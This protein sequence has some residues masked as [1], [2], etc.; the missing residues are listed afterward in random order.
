MTINGIS[1]SQS[2][3]YVLSNVEEYKTVIIP[4][5]IRELAVASFDEES[6]FFTF[7]NT[8][9]S[10]VPTIVEGSMQDGVKYVIKYQGRRFDGVDYIE[11][12]SAPTRAGT[13]T[14]NCYFFH[15]SDEAN[16]SKYRLLA[17]AEV[18]IDKV[19]PKLYFAGNVSQTYGSFSAI[20]AY[21]LAPGLDQEIEVVYSFE[22][23]DGT[24]PAFP[25]AGVH[26]VSASF[27]ETNDYLDVDGAQN[28]QIKQK[29][30][31]IS[32]DGYKNLVYNG[33]TRN[34]D[35]K[36]YFNGVVEGDT[37]EPIKIYNVDYVRDA[38]TYRLI[39]TPSNPS[40]MISGSN[41]VEFSIA[42]KVLNV[43]VP[44]GITTNAGVA[45]K[46]ELIITGFVENESVKDISVLPTPKI[47]SAKVGV[48][49][50]EFT[51][52]FDE[53]YSFNY[54]L[55][56][57]TVVYESENE[58]KTNITPYVVGGA[59]VGGIGL[60]FVVGY[61]VKIANY[62]AVA[63]GVAKRKIRKEMMSNS[64]KKK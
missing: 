33:Y 32:F 52:G 25:P 18:V 49:A 16:L 58:G 60:V 50:I 6:Y 47:T 53:N 4:A 59:A 46:I 41:S 15:Q 28:I 5:I 51:E 34:D 27:E 54:V 22:N 48:N 19:T 17:S 35:V 31:S 44:E 57:Y 30:I 36:A 39:V 9:K 3:N 40:Y 13:Y 63:R 21:V 56:V 61:L 7:D 43:S 38:G 20:K 14:A 45:P 2:S 29:T 42:K 64:I 37:C 10:V 55:G 24:L 26:T 62:K 23:E 8:P 11:Q 1:G 12:I